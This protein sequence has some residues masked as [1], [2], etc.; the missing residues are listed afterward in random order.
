M[1]NLEIQT[2]EESDYGLTNSMIKYMIECA[3]HCLNSQNHQ[4]GVKMR[5]TTNA[6]NYEFL[7]LK[8]EKKQSNAARFSM[9]DEERTT[10]FGANCISLLLT[11]HLTEYRYCIPSAK[12]TGFDFW[13]FTEE[14]EEF[15]YLKASARL[16]ISGI[17]TTTE[18]N[19]ISKRLYEKRRQVKKSD[20]LNLPVYIS[21]V[22]F[23][24]PE[25]VF[26]WR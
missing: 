14:P 19:T 26:E 1:M 21:I 15:D 5:L 13:L 22:E 24:K 10:D 17:R 4:T 12:G 11:I 18:Y 25:T 23:Q 2:L 9:N 3:Q 20:W 8:W 6:E 16:E 7:N